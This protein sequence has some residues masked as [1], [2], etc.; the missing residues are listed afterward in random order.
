MTVHM[1]ANEL[2]KRWAELPSREP[3]RAIDEVYSPQIVVVHAGVDLSRRSRA[4][5]RS[6]EQTRGSGR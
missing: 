1:D 2:A 6:T 5:R 4:E 3:D